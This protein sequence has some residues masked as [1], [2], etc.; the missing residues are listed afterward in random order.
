[1]IH[2]IHGRFALALVACLAGALPLCVSGQTGA[3]PGPPAKAPAPKSPTTAAPVAAGAEAVSAAA[4]FPEGFVLVA[5]V[6]EGDRRAEEFR[7]FVE[8][9]RVLEQPW[10]LRA[11][12]R[13]QA[14]QG[15][16]ALA[17]LA[18]TAGTDPWGAVGAMLGED[19]MVGLRPPR[20]GQGKEPDLLLVSV[21]RDAGLVDKLLL[22]IESLAGLLKAGKPDP[23]KSA[24]VRGQTV[25]HVGEKLAF[26]RAGPALIV[27]NNAGM[28]GEAL[29]AR[30]GERPA[31]AAGEVYRRAVQDAPREA[32]VW[33]WADMPR[34]QQA[35][36][37]GNAFPEQI[38]NPLGG[39]VFGGWLH[40]L[41]TGGQV[42]AWITPEAG[43]LAISAAI[44]GAE[45]LPATHAGFAWRGSAPAGAAAWLAGDLPR[46]MGEITVARDWARL[47]SDREAILTPAGAGQVVNF[48]NTITTL[49]GQ[50]DFMEQVLPAVA[51]P[52]RFIAAG[53]DFG[54]MG[55]QP[56]PRLPAFALVAPLDLSKDAQLEKR[57]YSGSQSALSLVNFDAANKKQPSYLIDTDRY[58]GYRMIYTEYADVGAGGADGKMME[59]GAGAGK[60]DGGA[61]GGDAAAEQPG[62]KRVVGQRYNFA[63][64][65]AVA[66]GQYIVATS[67]AM[68]ES[69]L[70][71]IA[72]AK[73]ADRR[74]GAPDQA[75]RVHLSVPALAQ[76]LDDNREEYLADQMLKK[77]ISREQ[78]E[79]E[80][81]VLRG[82]VG[83]FDS[84]DVGATRT[85]DGLRARVRVVLRSSADDG[86]DRGAPKE[87]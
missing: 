30:A 85:E 52:V 18:A 79:A 35:I 46:Y 39:F 20:D 10:A 76:L 71:A 44:G 87:R 19:L 23:A 51:G 54:A 32:A 36:A 25:F 37:K 17:G 8:G 60:K 55:F 68:L 11:L 26:C 69:V 72:A 3:P 57:L 65:V 66:E 74:G 42:S 28:V 34:L 58:A 7:R 2:V 50:L 78:A 9:S 82:V 29:A 63:P 59:P 24:E 13:P 61:A 80:L 6:R 64:A 86:R 38:N 45:A 22:N 73:K 77:D 75:D 33:I 40:A 67:K 1:M 81:G 41:R 5:T 43:A 48:S 27:A 21:P 12:E 83:L 4:Y 49:L 16:V 56:T 14:V 15:K 84:V 31:L 47:F 70:D 53:Q 62:G